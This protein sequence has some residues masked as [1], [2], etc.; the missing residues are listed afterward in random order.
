MGATTFI[1]W[2]DAT[3]NCIGGCSIKS[4]GCIRCY[5]QKLS[6]TRLRSHPLYAGTTTLVKGKPVF[7]GHLT[8]AAPDHDVW[9]WPV[10]WNGSKAPKLGPGLPS[11]IFVGDMSDLFHEDRPFAVIDRV[12]A[13]LIH[14]GRARHI[15]QLLTKRP[16]VMARYFTELREDGRWLMF[17]HPLF[18]RPNFDLTVARFEGCVV[19]RLWVG[20]SVERQRE[21]DERRRWMQ[22]LHD[23]GFVTFVSYEPALGPVDWT[24]W[25]FL[26]QIISGGESG[27]DDPRPSHLNSHRAA[28]DFCRANGIA[29]FFKQHGAWREMTMDELHTFARRRGTMP[30]FG[31]LAPDGDFIP[32]TAVGIAGGLAALMVRTD[33]KAN[34]RLLDGVEWSQFPRVERNRASAVPALL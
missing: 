23:M 2:T 32:R 17:P 22:G 6:G 27:K 15:G 10:R 14:T 30:E 20:C 3:W 25:E 9:S 33:K 13:P 5:A 29:Y 7:N 31:S 34:G 18:G 11:L 24:G 16:D 26:D 8:E 28:R 4:P 21:A 12:V 1:E 19:P